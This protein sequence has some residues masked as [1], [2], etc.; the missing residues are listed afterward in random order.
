MTR[1]RTATSGA[2]LAACTALALLLC[3]CVGAP[4]TGT[5]TLEVRAGA[6]PGGGA[7]DITIRDKNHRVIDHERLMPGASTAV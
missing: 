7:L 6:T 3:G 2:V 5:V 1:A 4:P